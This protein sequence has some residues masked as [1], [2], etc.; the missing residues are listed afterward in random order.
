ML[1]KIMSIMNRKPHGNGLEGVPIKQNRSTSEV[2]ESD[3]HVMM[4]TY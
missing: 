1:T 3:N 4:E 2:S